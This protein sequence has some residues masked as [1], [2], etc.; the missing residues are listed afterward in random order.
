LSRMRTGARDWE[1]VH[2]VTDSRQF[3]EIYDVATW[4]EYLRQEQERTTGEDRNLI[5]RA[6]ALAEEE[7][8]VRWFLPASA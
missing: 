5:D 3:R 6:S 1:L 7:P 8:R 4:R 2:S